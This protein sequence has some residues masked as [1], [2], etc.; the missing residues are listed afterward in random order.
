MGKQHW[1]HLGWAAAAG[2]AFL[3]GSKAGAPSAEEV[4]AAQAAA[5]GRGGTISRASATYGSGGRDSAASTGRRDGG[6]DDSPVT[7][8]FGSFTIDAGGIDAVVEQALRDPNPLTR[9]LAFAKLLEGMTPENAMQIRESLV[10][11]DAGGDAWNDFNYAWGAIAGKEAFDFAQVSD[12]PDL[13]AAMSGWA[14]ADPAGALAALDN[15]PEDLQGQ[16]RNLERSVI[17]GLAD[18]DLALASQMALEFG[19]DDPRHAGRLIRSVAN[20]ALRSGGP[21]TASQWVETLPDG[22][23]K[24]SAMRRVTERYVRDDPQAAAAWAEQFADQ[25]F[26]RSAIAE[27]GDEWAESDPQATM[28]WLETLPDG[29]AQNAGFSEALGEWEDRDPQAA[30]EYLM[31]M[32]PSPQ[33]DSAISGFARGYAWQD[34]DTAY[35]WAQAISDPQMRERSMT[36]VAEAY[37]RRDPLAALDW[38][39]SSGLSAE[40]Q[41][42]VTRPRGR[43]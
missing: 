21:E 18:T 3:V 2:A 15:L 33:R 23:A 10:A 8:L 20:E 14:A 11:Q 42:R 4:A 7:R 19:A 26:A 17:S 27:I 41:E 9:K 16:R 36:Q 28:A 35:A 1:I 37:F 38:L 43:R 30:G 24:G 6:G 5:D 39:Q 25:D 29:G 12:E 22:A 32:D 31:S 13:N 34:P 40:A